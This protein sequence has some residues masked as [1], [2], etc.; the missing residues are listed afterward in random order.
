M[1]YRK[2]FIGRRAWI[3]RLSLVSGVMLLLAGCLGNMANQPRYEPLEDSEFFTDSRSGRPLVD[4]TI[5]W[6]E[7]IGETIFETGRNADGTLAE[8]FPF[9][10]TLDVLQRGQER[11]NI[12]CS[13]CHGYVGNGEGM[14]VQRGFTSPP[15]FHTD[16]LR[17]APVG[18]I[19]GVI[20]N[21]FG[22]MYSYAYRVNPADR[23]AIV[24]Y[25]RALQFSQ[26]A[27][28]SAL[29]PEILDQIPE[30]NP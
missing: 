9:P 22:Q 16:S 20:T 24:A 6:N 10:V 18:H 5:S 12:F 2:L 15:S 14:I 19:F 29:P 4:R 28:V 13:P 11:Y 1:I 26:H 30:T 17:E 7:P 25:I 21:G 3:A 27:N 8:G 23:W